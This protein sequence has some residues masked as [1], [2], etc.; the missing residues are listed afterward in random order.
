MIR[1]SRELFQQ[2]TVRVRQTAA[3]LDQVGTGGESAVQRLSTPPSGD[4]AVVTAAQHVLG[5]HRAELRTIQEAQRFA[6]DRL[7][8]VYMRARA[9]IADGR[10]DDALRAIE[11][12]S[13]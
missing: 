12:S 1:D 4:P 11:T 6:K 10:D 2:A 8:I 3:G 13:T 9:L 7:A 5:E